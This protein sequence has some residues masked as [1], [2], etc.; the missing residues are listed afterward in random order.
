L[1]PFPKIS[2]HLYSLATVPDAATAKST[3]L[4][5]LRDR[6]LV[7]SLYKTAFGRAPEETGLAAWAREL[8]SGTSLQVV[9]ERLATSTEFRQRHGTSEEVDIKYISALYYNTLGR[10][11][12]LDALAFWLAQGQNGGTRGKVLEGVAGSA[13]SERACLSENG[14]D[15]GRWVETFDTI[16]NTDRAVIRAQIA[17]LAFRPLISVILVGTASNANL[18]RSFNSMIAQLYPYWEL[19]ITVGTAAETAGDYIYR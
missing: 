8:Q 16:S 11:P 7:N 10:E 9:A 15:Y 17:G 18:R 13:L 1:Q 4:P 12:N 2:A 6:L 19:C 14:A 5:D 3:G